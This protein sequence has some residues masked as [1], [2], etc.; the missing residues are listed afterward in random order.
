MYHR[1]E[2]G[3]HPDQLYLSP[4]KY[5]WF[6]WEPISNLQYMAVLTGFY[7]QPDSLN[8]YWIT[9]PRFDALSWVDL[10]IKDK[11]SR[12]LWN[13][14]I[15]PPPIELVDCELLVWGLRCFSIAY[16]L[17]ISTLSPK[18]HKLGS[19]YGL[20]CSLRLTSGSQAKVSSFQQN[21]TE[22]K[23][24]SDGWWGVHVAIS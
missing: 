11:W 22:N 23:S 15:H 3:S 21:G 14:C 13:K 20:L 7:T 6:G 24:T 5:E 19:S 18:G 9:Y 2:T 17:S 8:L 10:H 12:S 16:C 4:H 1:L